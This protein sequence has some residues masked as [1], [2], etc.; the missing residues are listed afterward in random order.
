MLSNEHIS[1]TQFHKNYPEFTGL[2]RVS[3]ASA[4][5]GHWPGMGG[6]GWPCLFIWMSSCYLLLVRTTKVI[7]LLLIVCRLVVV[8]SCMHRRAARERKLK[9][10]SPL[11]YLFPSQLLL[12][13][14]SVQVKSQRQEWELARCVPRYR[15][16]VAETWTV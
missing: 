7:G 3:W 5:N 2:I 13:C 1:H 16:G 12:P 9:C 4:V 8:C 6:L 10:A 11:K 15:H 14:W